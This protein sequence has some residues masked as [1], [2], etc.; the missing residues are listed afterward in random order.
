MWLCAEIF[1]KIVPFKV[2]TFTVTSNNNKNGQSPC[3]FIV[4]FFNILNIKL[5][6]GV[7]QHIHN[8]YLSWIS[9]DIFN[10][11]HFKNKIRRENGGNWLMT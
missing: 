6:N 8:I 7:T 4:Y 11:C 10:H 5:K 1:I 2:F 3:P 9:I